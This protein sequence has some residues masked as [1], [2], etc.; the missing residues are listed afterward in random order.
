MVVAPLA[1]KVLDIL[2]FQ[3]LVQAHS[4]CRQLRSPA[5]RRPYRAACSECQRSTT[6]R[7][8]RLH[9]G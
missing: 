9:R 7:P 1:Y 4:K 3:E 6:E 8:V 5:A 2:Y